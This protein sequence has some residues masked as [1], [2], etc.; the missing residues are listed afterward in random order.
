MS[1]VSAYIHQFACWQGHDF[2]MRVE[3]E[4]YGLDVVGPVLNRALKKECVGL[5]CN[6]ATMLIGHPKARNAC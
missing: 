5:I 1:M 6:L 2:I 4:G 3:L